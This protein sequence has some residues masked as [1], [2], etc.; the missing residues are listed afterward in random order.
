M[1]HL[2]T[3]KTC[4]KHLFIFTCICTHHCT[5][6]MNLRTTTINMLHNHQTKHW[7]NP[8]KYPPFHG[9]CQLVLRP[10]R[11]A[12]NTIIKICTL[13]NIMMRINTQNHRYHRKKPLHWLCHRS[14]SCIIKPTFELFDG[15]RMPYK[16]MACGNL[17]TRSSHMY[18]WPHCITKAGRPLR[19]FHIGIKVNNPASWSDRSTN[20]WQYFIHHSSNGANN[21]AR[22]QVKDM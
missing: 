1:A 15:D 16:R 12:E 10:C 18:H 21:L 22:M 19:I 7:L 5:P 6:F 20:L 9:D 13:A 8:S 14:Q 11:N 4:D 3:T 2:E 17:C